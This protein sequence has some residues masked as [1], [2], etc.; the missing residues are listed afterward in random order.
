MDIA[1][2]W[3]T[4]EKKHSFFLPCVIFDCLKSDVYAFVKSGS[5]LPKWFF[6]R[7]TSGETDE[8][9]SLQDQNGVWLY[10]DHSVKH[11]YETGMHSGTVLQTS[12]RSLCLLSDLWEKAYLYWHW[13][14]DFVPDHRAGV[15]VIF[16]LQRMRTV[17]KWRFCGGGQRV[18]KN[19]CGSIKGTMPRWLLPT[20]HVGT[21]LL[22]RLWFVS[23]CV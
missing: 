16:W 9:R 8:Q 15:C 2:L 6:L 19:F 18:Q 4:V 11:I 23:L 12:L 3:H 22:T 10:H 1:Y 13:V 21:E 14:I 17:E 7:W 20:C 5:H